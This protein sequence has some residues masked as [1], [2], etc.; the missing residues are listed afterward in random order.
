MNISLV[1]DAPWWLIAVCFAIGFGFAS[2][3]Y[4]KNT[5]LVDVTRP[6]IGILFILRF[7]LI[8]L[9]SLFLLSPLLKSIFNSTERPIIVLATDNSNSVVLYKDSLFIKESYLK[10]MDEL[11]EKIKSDFEVHT[12]SF[13]SSVNEIPGS[14][15]LNFSEKQTDI[16]Q[17]LEEL[18]VRFANRNLAA[19]VLSSDGLYN[20]GNNPV[21]ILQQNNTRFFTIALGDTTPVTD[22]SVSRVDHNE[23]AFLGNKFPLNVQ[24]SAKKLANRKATLN[25]SKGS[26]TIHSSIVEIKNESAFFEIPLMLEADQIGLQHYKVSLTQFDEEQNKQNNIRDVFIDVLDSR[27]KILVLAEVPHPDVAAIK[28]S[29]SGNDNYEVSSQLFKENTGNLN[30]Y[31]LIIGV[32][33]T[34]ASLKQ[35]NARINK[36]VPLW[37]ITGSSADLGGYINIKNSVDRSNDCEPNL[38][39]TFSLFS[40]SKELQSFLINNAPA[41]RCPFGT[42]QLAV[43]MQHF[44]YQT[45]GSIETSTP[46][47]S[48]S[49]STEQKFAIFIGE[50][51]WR[52]RLRDFSENGNHQ[53]FNELISKTVQYL[54][55]K[56]DK[57][58]FRLTVNKRFTEE[59][60]VEFKAELYNQSYEAVNEPDVNLVITNNDGKKFSYNFSK[61]EKAYYLNAGL[62]PVG[63]YNYEATV[64]YNGKIH[65]AKGGFVIMAI[66]SEA[67]ITQANHQLMYALAEVGNGKMY[68][69]TNLQALEK[70]LTEQSSFKSIIHSEKKYNDLVN[71]KWV[72]FLLVV[73]LTIEWSIRKYFG[74]Y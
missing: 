53:N 18:N 44:L 57:N 42:Y 47:M 16:S 51:L 70:E 20:R 62:L 56:A 2:I 30:G 63:S 60:Q 69:P 28:E 41:V 13:G 55:L 39:K 26:K 3:L 38:D 9:L 40:I 37:L 45:I 32:G 43:P 21:N 74:G 4:F 8:S 7:V 1:F 71:V 54:S 50:G 27:Q 73:L 35:L 10:K 61:S 15:D 17:L 33:L 19:I 72:F 66:Q 31:N 29:I 65:T 6:V 52:W 11:V 12:F 48:F 59:E 68:Y 5:R 34:T 49:N 24:I 36:T 58:V 64:N 22:L 14:T 23:L 67:A 25:V 46:M